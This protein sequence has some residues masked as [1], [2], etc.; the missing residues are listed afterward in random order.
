MQ[1]VAEA[2]QRA[3]YS[4][5]GWLWLLMP[6]A[7]VYIL[8]SAIRRQLYELGI[9]SS[10]QV[11]VPVIIVGNIVAGGSGK[12][13]VVLAL[14][15]ALIKLGCK[16]GIVSRGYGGNPPSTPYFVTED[17]TAYAAGDEPLLLARRSGC[18]CVVDRNRVRAVQVL[19][20]SYDCDVVLADDGLQHYALQRDIEIAVIDSNRGLGN[21]Q[22][23]PVGPLRESST[24]LREVDYIVGCTV[25]ISGH[26]NKLT[27]VA[28]V[29]LAEPTRRKDVAYFKDKTAHCVAGIGNPESFFSTCRELGVNVAPHPLADH[30]A[31]IDQVLAGM[32]AGADTPVL[33]TEKDA[34]KSTNHRNA[35]HWYLEV[36]AELPQEFLDE[37]ALKLETV[38]RIRES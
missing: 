24:R 20:E 12:T 1:R 38:R 7:W 13:P 31:D 25:D 9:L 19:L 14:A 3:W 21:G 29:N 18:P 37:L 11:A 6:V 8:L 26:Q 32:S 34:V 28:W 2:I 15:E 17:S 36:V 33:M 22:R 23:L 16:P 5:P 27:P 4:Q 30:A 35:N 10:V